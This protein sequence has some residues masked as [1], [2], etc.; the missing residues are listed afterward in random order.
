MPTQTYTP[1]ARQ[2]LAAGTTTVT[3]SSIPSGYTD[4]E[5][6]VNHTSSAGLGWF[7]RVNG[8]TGSNYS[9][10]YMLG[11]GSTAQSYRDANVTLSR[12]GNA[13][14][15]QGNTIVKF[16]NYSNT[17][18]NKTF[19]SRS[20]TASNITMACVGLWRN[21]SAITSITILTNVADTFSVGSIFTLYGIKAGS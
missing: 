21:T 1:I 9:G 17:T 20:G 15:T 13:Y 19:L 5:L 10:T 16:Q 3:L 12:A 11:D 2:V 18:T 6:V 14:T 4:L 8:D 7:V